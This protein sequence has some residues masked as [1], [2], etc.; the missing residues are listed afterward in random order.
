MTERPDI[1]ISYAHLDGQA[2]TAELFEPLASQ[3]R[4]SDGSR[5][6]VFFDSSR[7]GGL[8]PG[9]N[10]RKQLQEAIR[11]CRKFVPVFSEFYFQQEYCEWE[12]EQAIKRDL[13]GKRG[14]IVP[15]NLDASKVPSEYDSI[16]YIA[17]KDY[18]DW[19]AR[20]CG[21]LELDSH[22]EQ[23][24]VDFVTQPQNVHI[25]QHLPPVCL[26]VRDIN[27]HQQ[28]VTDT[29]CLR[30]EHDA[31]LQGET[32]RPAA[33]G[34]VEFSNLSF[35]APVEQTRLIASGTGIE[36]TFSSPFRVEGAT[37]EIQPDSPRKADE[38]QPIPVRGRPVFFAGDTALAVIAA[39]EISTF[40]LPDCA[41]LLQEPV[42]F[43]GPVRASV[44]SDDLL[45][46]C[47][48]EGTLH[49]LGSNG[50][51]DTWSFRS[52]ERS[53]NVI[54]DLAIDDGAV[55]VGLWSG[56]VFR[57]NRGQAPILLFQHPDGVQAMAVSDGNVGL[58]DLTGVFTIYPVGGQATSIP[59]EPRV[60]LLKSCS[61]HWIAVG[62]ERL[63]Q[64]AA[65]GATMA[66]ENT[67]IHG[68]AS[69]LGQTRFPVL[70][71]ESGRGVR[72][73]E[74]LTSKGL[75]HTSAGARPVSA[76]DHGH[77]CVFENPGGAFTLMAQE[78]VQRQG[79][80]IHSHD[81]PMAISQS[82]RFLAVSEPDGIRLVS[83]GELE[84]SLNTSPG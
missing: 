9:R 24:R 27:G 6:K 73:N 18:A 80:I 4:T 35:G 56:E 3:T 31:E 84:E 39:R 2:V 13:N 57:L 55:Y 49:V 77:W 36:E 48:W 1:F 19:F 60:Y 52:D 15:V 33:D 40:R 23:L 78:P 83:P 59:L 32:T 61:D 30:A 74:H 41:P 38:T 75:F 70:I 58:V 28:A 42:S 37:A 17:K 63:Y 20:L 29:I 53:V 8:T 16:H 5:P 43:E 11:T 51:S 79:R 26:Q 72:V 22:Y 67:L 7:D 81:G 68:I 46:L 47:D 76:D 66:P 44:Q 50:D 71:E 82:G 25:N 62:R 65:D 69:A 34:R 10:F 45:A 21:A 54:G 14:I 12:L 64:I